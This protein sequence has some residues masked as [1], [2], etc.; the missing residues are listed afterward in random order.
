MFQA[1]GK[2]VSFYFAEDISALKANRQPGAFQSVRDKSDCIAQLETL[3]G[4]KD[5]GPTL[6]A[7]IELLG[8]RSISVPGVE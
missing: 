6:V 5:E 3:P 2:Q 1:A 7:A 4:S 8:C